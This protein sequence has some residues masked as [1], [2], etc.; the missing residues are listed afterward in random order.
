MRRWK[1]LEKQTPLCYNKAA[2]EKP[3]KLLN[4]AEVFSLK[5]FSAK[6]KERLLKI[7]VDRID[8]NP[9]Q[10]RRLF[11]ET[12]IQALSESIQQN[13]LL[14]PLT[15]RHEKKT[16]RYTLIAGERRLRALKQ[17]GISE[18]LCVVHEMAD[19]QAAILALVENIQ[20]QDLTFFEEAEALRAL[21]T[22][23]NLSQQELGDK[24][25]KAQSTVANKLR[26]LRYS[27]E[28][29][30]LFLQAQLTE[31]H[32]RALVRL[33]GSPLLYKAVEKVQGMHLS[34]DEA[35]KLAEQ[36]G[37]GEE[38]AVSPKRKRQPIIRDVRVFVN[39]VKKAVRVM[40]ESGIPVRCDRKDEKDH[41][42]YIIRIPI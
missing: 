5:K 20:R 21:M 24:L 41:I 13:G 11:N 17:A 39:T 33:S 42:E 16:G 23:W 8:P 30:A 18:A 3:D 26:L 22:E 32:A 29:R 9:A 6:P 36:L 1:I 40:K 37:L 15:V 25:G 28:E 35:E 34:A 27:E 14:Q 7:P 31:R 10:P 2:V 4:S 12:E 38:E 19:R